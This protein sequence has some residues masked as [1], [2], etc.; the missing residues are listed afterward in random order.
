[1]R[2]SGIGCRPKSSSRVWTWRRWG[3]LATPTSSSHR[4]RTRPDTIDPS[5][6]RWASRGGA[7]QLLR[8]HNVHLSLLPA[9]DD[10]LEPVRHRVHPGR[11]AAAESRRAARHCGSRA[12]CRRARQ[13]GDAPAEEGMSDLLL[14]VRPPTALSGPAVPA[15]ALSIPWRDP[16][17]IP[18]TELSAY[19]GA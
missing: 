4:G 12:Q 3:R 1:M 5:A 18:P 8:L 16:H 9:R 13:L 7:R 6:T 10:E 11:R 15:G 17:V 14:T 19:I 2:S